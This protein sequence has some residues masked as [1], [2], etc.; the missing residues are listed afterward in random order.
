MSN[1]DDIAYRLGNYTHVPEAEHISVK[2]EDV[3]DAMREI[4]EL[5][6]EVGAKQAH[7]DRLMWEFCPDEMTEE[8]IEEWASRQRN[9]TPEEMDALNR[10][11]EES[12]DLIDPGFLVDDNE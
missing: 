4:I 11:L 3:T 8:Q 6:K 9:A 5:R 1:F 7:I 2:R 12:T 10:A